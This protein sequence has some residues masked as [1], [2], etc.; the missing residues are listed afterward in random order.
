MERDGEW[1][2][3]LSRQIAPYRNHHLHSAADSPTHPSP[4]AEDVA[5]Q[6][7]AA[8]RLLCELLPRVDEEM[9]EAIL[10]PLL[11]HLPEVH[12]QKKRARRVVGEPPHASGGPEEPA[13]THPSAGLVVEQEVEQELE[14]EEE[15]E[16]AEAEEGQEGQEEGQEDQEEGQEDQEDEQEEDGDTLPRVEREQEGSEGALPRGRRSRR[17]HG[18]GVAGYAFDSRGRIVAVG[19]D[20]QL[21]SQHLPGKTPHDTL[22]YATGDNPDAFVA[23][24]AELLHCQEAGS[25]T[26]QLLDMVSRL[27][28]TST[29]SEPPSPC[30]PP[31]STA[32]A[33]LEAWDC[34]SHMVH[35]R[36]LLQLV[37]R[38]TLLA[39]YQIGGFLG[40][41]TATATTPQER[42][43]ILA[44]IAN[45]ACREEGR[46]YRATLASCG[47]GACARALRWVDQGE[48]GRAIA[49]CKRSEVRARFSRDHTANLTPTFFRQCIHLH[50]T[51][52]STHPLLTASITEPTISPTHIRLL[53]AELQRV[54]CRLQRQGSPLPLSLGQLGLWHRFE[55]TSRREEALDFVDGDGGFLV[56]AHILG[57]LAF[58]RER[59]P[60][61]TWAEGMRGHLVQF[62]CH[63]YDA[64][65]L[66]HVYHGANRAHHLGY[67][68]LCAARRAVAQASSVVIYTAGE[69]DI[70]ASRLVC[71]V[72]TIDSQGTATSL[73]E[74]LLRA[75]LAHP[76]PGAPATFLS[77]YAEA[78]TAAA[79][80]FTVF[81]PALATSPEVR[82]DRLRTSFASSRRALHFD[83]Q[84]EDYSVSNH[85]ALR[86]ASHMLVWESREQGAG[87]GAFL[88]SRSPHQHESPFIRANAILC[89]YGAQP[90]SNQ[91]LANLPSAE[92]E[93]TLTVRRTLHFNSFR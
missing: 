45:A 51:M 72:V 5:E 14:Q 29:V 24:A 90:I 37:N 21:P 2:P 61:T 62:R 40:R 50:S 31:A 26:D 25:S 58:V 36:S 8:V 20:S 86:C 15:E 74:T 82:P 47:C 65:E 10:A 13:P 68:A 6:C 12:P 44:A 17:S 34:T 4:T 23:M 59:A 54:A 88:R 66:D 75:G 79:G 81:P 84:G 77:A 67:Q 56:A 53:V 30:P 38:V 35:V 33:D 11:H 39:H 85:S 60:T 46:R 69:M 80:I 27:T 41:A 64:V 19:S 89:C 1:P 76:M 73:A 93:Y 42:H 18:D 55:V 70:R 7:H 83:H 48:R 87:Q 92:L 49:P 9:A 43:G 63:A 78:E 91:E 16:E 3:R 52:P 28:D 71:D 32:L 22:H 57:L